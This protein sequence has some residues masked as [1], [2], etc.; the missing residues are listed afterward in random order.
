VPRSHSACEDSPEKSAGFRGRPGNPNGL[1]RPKNSVLRDYS[2]TRSRLPSK[3][4]LGGPPSNRG[5]S[6]GTGGQGAANQG[7]DRPIKPWAGPP[8]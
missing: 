4:L 8:G 6:Q 7:A 1:G 2:E 3:V 5:K